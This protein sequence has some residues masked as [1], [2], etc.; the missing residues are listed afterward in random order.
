M[1]KAVNKVKSGVK[2]EILSKLSEVKEEVIRILMETYDVMLVVTDRKSKT[3]PQDPK[4]RDEF[5]KRLWDFEYINDKGDKVGFKLPDMET[6]DF[7]GNVMHV[8]EQILEGTAGIYVEVNAEDYEAMFGKRIISREPLDTSVPKKELIYLM[9]YNNVV[10]AA[11]KRVF[12]RNNYLVRYPF[13]NTPPIPLLDAADQFV[14]GNM[15]RWM[16]EAV[17]NAVKKAKRGM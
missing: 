15:D 17:D 3:N 6:F 10:R 13:S 1:K 11:E 12:G 5:E 9:R 8:I 7:S 4:Y 14:K 2:N 16:D